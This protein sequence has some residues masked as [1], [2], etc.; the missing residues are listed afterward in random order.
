[1][2]VAVISIFLLHLALKEEEGI[3]KKKEET[4]RR[5]KG[6]KR[7]K[8]AGRRV[9]RSCRMPGTGID[10]SWIALGGHVTLNRPFGQ[11]VHQGGRLAFVPSL[12]R[13]TVARTV[14]VCRC[15]LVFAYFCWGVP[16]SMLQITTE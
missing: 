4:G 6:R 13:Y 9:L 5:G 16:A 10:T 8:E 2:I 1:M 11:R 15:I 3:S 12:L 14:G 7:R